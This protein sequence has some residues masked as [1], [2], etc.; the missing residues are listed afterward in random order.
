ML[1]Y[2][3]RDH[4][5]FSQKKLHYGVPQGSVLGP[6]LFTLY[7]QPLSKVIS[8]SRCGHHIFADNTQLHQSSTPSDFH[9][10]IVDVEQCVDSAGRW[11]AGNRLKL[12]N[13]KTEALLV[14]L[15][16]GSACHKKTT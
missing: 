9:S 1:L 7:I 3:N 2:V 10:L 5:D 15:V 11:L 8:R 14:G 6:V 4:T 13:D 16:K 12:N